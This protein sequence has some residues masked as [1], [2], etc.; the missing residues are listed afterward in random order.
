MNGVTF[1]NH[2]GP[3]NLFAGVV[4]RANDTGTD[5]GSIFNVEYNIE[6]GDKTEKGYATFFVTPGSSKYIQFNDGSGNIQL[7]RVLSSSTEEVEVHDVVDTTVS[8]GTPPNTLNVKKSVL[9]LRVA[10]IVS[11]GNANVDLPIE[12]IY[13]AEAVSNIERILSAGSLMQLQNESKQIT[14]ANLPKLAVYE[15]T[16]TAQ[17]ILSEKNSAVSYS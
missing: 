10:P 2:Y 7:A 1:I 4:S 16:A 6:K 14:Q 3:N 17:K 13:N 11:G 5:L 12:V 9:R 15:P 8:A